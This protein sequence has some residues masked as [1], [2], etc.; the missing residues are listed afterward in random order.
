M[1]TESFD[2]LSCVA[3]YSALVGRALAKPSH[4]LL[5]NAILRLTFSSQ[6]TPPPSDPTIQRA[7]ML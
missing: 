6:L 2:C 1:F 7:L 4:F 5:S 3:E